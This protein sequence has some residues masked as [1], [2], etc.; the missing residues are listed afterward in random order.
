MTE[1]VAERYVEGARPWPIRGDARRLL[2]RRA[3]KRTMARMA[4][5]S[6]RR[7]RDRTG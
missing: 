5:R 4:R 3:R 6:R 7:W 1:A 2:A